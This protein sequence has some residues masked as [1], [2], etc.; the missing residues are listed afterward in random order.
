MPSAA[1]TTKATSWSRRTWF[2]SCVV[3]VITA[4]YGVDSAFAWEPPSS[5][6]L[7]PVTTAA[8]T[9]PADKVEV[10]AAVPQPL[11]RAD[12]ERYR[13]VFALQRLAKWREADAAM[14][15]LKD[16]SLLGTLLAQRYLHPTAYWSK[17]AELK[18]WLDRYADHPDAAKIYALALKRQPSGAASLT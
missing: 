6:Q 4:T 12:A 13:R 7:K 2:I 9:P 8:L 3:A 11:S 15:T 16:K 17:Y 18:A 5:G 1:W 14:A 10:Q